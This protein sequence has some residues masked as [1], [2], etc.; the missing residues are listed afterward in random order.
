MLV[1]HLGTGRGSNPSQL[2]EDHAQWCGRGAG[3]AQ[4]EVSLAIEGV[5]LVVHRDG[6]WL[7]RVVAVGKADGLLR[8]F[9][10]AE[11]A[12]GKQRE[13]S[14]AKAGGGSIRN[15]HRLADYIG[16]DLVEHSVV[17]W[18]AAGVDNALDRDTVLGHAFENDARV[19]R[20]ALNRGEEFVLSGMQQ[21]PAEGDAAKFRIDQH[22]AV[23]VVPAE[24]QQ[25]G[26]PWTILF[27]SICEFPYLDSS[28]PCDC[29]EDVS[30]RGKACFNACVRG[31]HAAGNNAA[32]SGDKL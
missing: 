10:G 26:L 13:D 21:V 6:F 28:T 30:G 24:T 31:V 15:Q 19:K 1:S 14:G 20:C 7:R 27:Q 22:C 3:L 8:F 9:D 23:A 4:C 29:L 5:E 2:R 32:D 25:A 17:L 18:N 12:G 11:G 16:V